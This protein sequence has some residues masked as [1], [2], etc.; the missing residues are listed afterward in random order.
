[1]VV[2]IVAALAAAQ[3]NK[4]S[5][6]IESFRVIRFLK[7]TFAGSRLL[8]FKAYIPATGKVK[9]FRTLS[10]AKAAVDG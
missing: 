8:T 9:R 5:R 6:E 1:M 2:F 4:P 3:S 7:G 10:L